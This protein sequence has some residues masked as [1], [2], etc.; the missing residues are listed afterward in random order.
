MMRS[1]LHLIPQRSGRKGSS[2]LPA[3]TRD[4]A[5]R[6]SWPIGVVGSLRR[7]KHGSRRV[8]LVPNL[9]ES[10]ERTVSCPAPWGE[11]ESK[12]PLFRACS[13]VW[14]PIIKCFEFQRIA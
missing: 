13:G 7:R 5:L 14:M 8:L 1:F 12:S 6:S 10:W 4:S 11:K 9:S 2:E 3:S